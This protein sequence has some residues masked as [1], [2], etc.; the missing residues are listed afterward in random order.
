MPEEVQL[1]HAIVC[2]LDDDGTAHL[3][4]Q[5]AEGKQML[6]RLNRQTLVMLCSSA[7]HELRRVDKRLERNGRT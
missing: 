2:A 4:C 6:F 5:T 1:A 7:G 3:N